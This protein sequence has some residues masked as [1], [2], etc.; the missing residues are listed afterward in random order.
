MAGKP[1]HLNRIEFIALHDEIIALIDKGH[2]KKSAFETLMSQ[3]R[4]EH[5]TYRSFL[6]F[7][8]AEEALGP[9]KNKSAHATAKV[10]AVAKDCG[11]SIDPKTI[12]E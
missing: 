4:I 12:W 3:G 2:T 10:N 9:E 8:K 7:I 1:H 6:R 5:L 11:I